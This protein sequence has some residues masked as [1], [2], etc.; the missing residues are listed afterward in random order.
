LGDSVA[1]YEGN[2]L[3]IETVNLLANLSG[4]TGKPLS[5]QIRVVEV[6][7]REDHAEWGTVLTTTSTIY[8]P[9]YLTE[10]WTIERHKG[11]TTGYEYPGN[12]CVPPL[13]ERPANVWPKVEWSD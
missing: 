8:D 5:D 9:V 7:S 10:P 3:V 4:H 12:D 2:T 6:Y 13:R 1:R 11:Y